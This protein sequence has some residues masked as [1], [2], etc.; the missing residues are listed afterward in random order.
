M[1]VSPIDRPYIT[2]VSGLPRSGTSMMMAMLQAGGIEALSDGVRAADEDNPRGYFE[3]EPVKQLALDNTWLD[4]A[5]GKSIKVISALL[6]RLPS[7]Y[8]YRV[9]FMQRDMGEVL[10]SQRAMLGRRGRSADQ[11]DDERMAQL[12]EKHLAKVRDDIAA[13]D[14]MKVL[15]VDHANVIK[16]PISAA[17]LVNEFV[18]GICDVAAMK[19]AV[20]AG[21]YR[22]RRMR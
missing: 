13:R 10:A 17:E 5:A 2:V 3:L 20:E 1:A 12:F 8:D 16:E 21:L 4:D 22:Q 11:P 6:E 18:G 19:D 15:Y 14:E 7:R 9:L